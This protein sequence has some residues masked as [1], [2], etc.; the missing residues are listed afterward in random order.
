MAP[1]FCFGRLCPW[2]DLLLVEEQDQGGARWLFGFPLL[3][4]APKAGRKGPGCT[5]QC[6]SAV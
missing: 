1:A 2:P 5:P 3:H 6:G 4:P